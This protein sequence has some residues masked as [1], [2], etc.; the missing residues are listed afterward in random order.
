[1]VKPATFYFNE[2]TAQN[3]SFQTPPSKNEGKLEIHQ[4]AISEFNGLVRL[5]RSAGV[6]VEIIEE[7][8]DPV[9]TDS[10]FPNNWLSFHTEQSESTSLSTS[11][12]EKVG[13][14]E[15]I[16]V[17]DKTAVLYPMWS[18]NRRLERVKLFP[19]VSKILHKGTTVMDLSAL[20][21]EERYLEGT[22]SLVLDRNNKIAYACLSPRTTRDAVELFCKRMGYKPIIFNAVDRQGKPIYHTNVMMSIA[23]KY[24]VI[25]LDSIEDLRERVE[26]EVSIKNLEKVIVPITLDQ[27]NQFA[28]N[29]LQLRGLDGTFLVMSSRAFNSLT[30]KQID[31]IGQ[32]DNILNTDITTIE[33]LGGGSVR[34]MIAE[35]GEV[36]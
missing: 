14:D 26:V 33:N 19:Q 13:I 23:D 30:E 27:M 15:V 2:E 35:L 36:Q 1:M 11:T 9:T 10:V 6:T 21:S 17:V 16:S 4:K 24:C 32:F 34:C 3:N 12:T 7:S 29:C 5:L 31:I 8:P 22:G 20:E 18:E 25:C 28:G